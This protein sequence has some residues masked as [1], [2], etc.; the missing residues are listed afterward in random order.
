V[1]GEAEQRRKQSIVTTDV[2]LLSEVQTKN[3][4]FSFHSSLVENQELNISLVFTSTSKVTFF[5][6]LAFSRLTHTFSHLLH[7]NYF[8][9]SIF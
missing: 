5:S 7:V 9:K 8:Y 6:G 3:G 1:E 2:Y 4:K